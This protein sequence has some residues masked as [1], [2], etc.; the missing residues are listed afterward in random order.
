ML[1]F[2]YP[3]LNEPARLKFSCGWR[4]FKYIIFDVSRLLRADKLILN[5][6]YFFHETETALCIEASRN[7]HRL[8]HYEN[9]L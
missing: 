1:T 8:S 2:F 6:T 3:T 9:C 7:W 5:S 4:I